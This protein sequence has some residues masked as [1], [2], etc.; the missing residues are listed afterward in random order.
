M[1]PLF[2][3]W[4]V[5]LLGVFAYKRSKAERDGQQSE[6]EFWQRENKANATRKQDISGLDYVDFTGVSLPFALFP[7]DF[8]AQCESQ[9]MALKDQKILNL[10]GISNTDLKLQYGAANLPA[11][12]QCD[13]NF[14]LLV[15]TLNSWGHRLQELSQPKEA[16]A[17][18]SFAVEI[19]SDI[20][21][22]YQ[23]LAELYQQ[24]GQMHKVQELASYAQKLN[25]LMKQPIL[26]MLEQ[27]GS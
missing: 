25:S 6:Q 17:V 27:Y 23:L 1:F 7:D 21:A 20:K 3:G 2:L 13:Q 19:G 10:T 9:V 18:L 26:S 15:R 22:T 12:T 4:F 5:I 11:L 14:T 8:L 16:I 24:E